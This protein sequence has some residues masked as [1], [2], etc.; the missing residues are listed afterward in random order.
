[1][2]RMIIAATG[3]LCAEPDDPILYRGAYEEICAQAA[4]DGYSAIEM[5]IEDSD[6]IDREALWRTL[7]ANG[8]YL[9]SIGTGSIFFSRGYSLTS[10]DEETRRACIAHLGRHMI[11]AAPYGAVVIVGCVQGRLGRG[12]TPEAFLSLMA[13]SLR[14]LDAMAGT[15]GVT[16]GL[17]IM[18]R[19][20][21][22]VLTTI[23]EG[24]AFV[25]E[26]GFRHVKLHLDTVH[27]NIEEAAIGDAIRRAGDLVGHIH[28]ADND[29]WYP[30]HAHY[31]FS[32]TI[33]ALRDIGYDGALALEM[34]P[35]PDVRTSGRL[36]LKY[37]ERIV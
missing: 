8:L 37:L 5:H 15:Y 29:R 35:Y 7:E 19:F 16:I 10:A 25:R 30:G 32:E 6:A 2:K 17:E 33:D 4:E 20:E 26:Q 24:I 9:T 3:A 12:Q 36:A 27:M 28:L 14:R 11:T 21:S 34:K 31:D 18:N 13:D 22:D 23:D 1:M